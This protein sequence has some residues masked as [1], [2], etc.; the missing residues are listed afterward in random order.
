MALSKVSVTLNEFELGFFI[1]KCVCGSGFCKQGGGGGWGGGGGGGGGE[2][3]KKI[4]WRKET[5]SSHS[6]KIS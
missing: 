1:I 3:S 5:I 6:Q 4:R 2:G